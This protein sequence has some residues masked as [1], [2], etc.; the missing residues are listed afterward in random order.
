MLYVFIC[1][2]IY[3]SVLPFISQ[4]SIILKEMGVPVH[5]IVLLRKLYT[6]QEAI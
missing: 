4:D 1:V 2:Y 3:I 5:L 6:K